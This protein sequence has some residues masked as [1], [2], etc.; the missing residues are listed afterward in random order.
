MGENVSYPGIG[1]TPPNKVW[2][3]NVLLASLPYTLELHGDH[4]CLHICFFA[5]SLLQFL[6][7][8]QFT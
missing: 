8:M 6:Q 7:G 3:T 4:R 1:S 2:Q 5:P